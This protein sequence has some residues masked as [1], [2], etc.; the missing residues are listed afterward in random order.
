[1]TCAVVLLNKQFDEE[2]ITVEDATTIIEDAKKKFTEI[3]GV[4]GK[5]SLLDQFTNNWYDLATAKSA[6]NAI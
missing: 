2:E 4:E 3:K 6:S 1:M 5:E